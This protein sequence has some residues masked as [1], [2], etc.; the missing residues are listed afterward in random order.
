MP[1]D[2]TLVKILTSSLI[3]LIIILLLL[4]LLLNVALKPIAHFLNKSLL[5]LI[6]FL[7]AFVDYFRYAYVLTIDLLSR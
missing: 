7:L 3:D 2:L 6:D 1:F 4:L 5:L